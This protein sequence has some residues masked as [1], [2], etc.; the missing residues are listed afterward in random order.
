MPRAIKKR[1]DKTEDAEPDLR[2]TVVDLRERLG[3]RQRYLIYGLVAFIIVTASAVGFLVYQSST[4]DRALQLAA[5]ADQVLYGTSGVQP[6]A[7]AEK[8]KKALDLYRESYS[9]RKNAAVL[10]S[11]ANAQ[12]SLGNY[13]EALTSLKEL[14][15]RFPDS[16]L[17]ALAYF[18]TAMTYEK[19]KDLANAVGTLK[20]LSSIKNGSLQ[21]LA[22]LETGRIL[23][24]QGKAEEA[25]SSYRDLVNR[26]PQSP[27]LAQAKARLGEKVETPAAPQTK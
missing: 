13:D 27:L 16:P 20:N 9:A 3:E 10:L 25:K 4:K 21:D 7:P 14:L 8:Y 19:K 24:Q 18:K 11:V 6:A 12:Y 26:F 23:E 5:E 1:L 15:E 2:E 22:L 17:T